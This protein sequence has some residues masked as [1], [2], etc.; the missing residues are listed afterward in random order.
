MVQYWT[1]STGIP[2]AAAHC[3]STA[4]M[5]A[6]SVRTELCLTESIHSSGH[7]VWWAP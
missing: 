5:I 3:Q 7:V 2:F 6:Y 4:E 1:G